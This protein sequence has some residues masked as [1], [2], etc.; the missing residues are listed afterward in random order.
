MHLLVDDICK[1]LNSFAVLLTV[2]VALLPL[3]RCHARYLISEVLYFNF[4]CRHDGQLATLL[5][6]EKFRSYK[7]A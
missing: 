3:L 6:D 5:D 7:S 4:H 2:H 1:D